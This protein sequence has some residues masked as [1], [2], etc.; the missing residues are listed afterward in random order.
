[1]DHWK[2]D[3]RASAFQDCVRAGALI[4]IIH[5]PVIGDA[6]RKTVIHRATLDLVIRVYVYIWRLQ[7]RNADKMRPVR[8]YTSLC[9][10]EYNQETL[11]LIDEDPEFQIIIATIAFS[12]GMNARR[13][14]ERDERKEAWHAAWSWFNLQWWLQQRSNFKKTFHDKREVERL[15]RN[16]KARETTAKRKRAVW[17]GPSVSLVASPHHSGVARH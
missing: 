6:D 11:H 8:M 17:K 10:A 4:Y 1:M 3:R 5:E 16:T 12:N 13:R 14:D 7:R 9:S 2:A 15:T